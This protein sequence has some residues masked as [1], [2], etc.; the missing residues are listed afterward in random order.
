MQRRLLS[1]I[2][3]VLVGALTACS[4]ATQSSATAPPVSQPTP[5]A[6][7]AAPAASPVSVSPAPSASPAASPAASILP[8]ASVS[9]GAVPSPSAIGATTAPPSGAAP[10]ATTIANPDA[11]WVGNT[12]G[13][14]V[15]LRNSPQIGDRGDVLADGTSVT[16]T[17]EQ[18]EGDGLDWYPVRTANG[19]EGYVTT[20]YLTR[21][22]PTGTP[23]APT[24]EPK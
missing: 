6:S 15:Y 2:A 7:V 17:G 3:T 13:G 21:T 8:S 9:P 10:L 1:S 11:V 4:G 16:I 24:G 18:V 23:T 19:S 5:L 12:D 22:T 14:G 20:T